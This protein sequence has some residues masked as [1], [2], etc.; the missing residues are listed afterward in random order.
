MASESRR[1][2]R[3]RDKR[4]RERRERERQ[5]HIAQTVAADAK[6]P[7][8]KRAVR[9]VVKYK[10][11]I[12]WITGAIAAVLAIPTVAEKWFHFLPRMEISV[13]IP[14]G[15]HEYDPT[16]TVK[17]V[18][19]LPARDVV[20]TCSVTPLQTGN[21]NPRPGPPTLRQVVTTSR[22]L[23][24]EELVHDGSV[25]SECGVAAVFSAPGET[26]RPDIAVFVYFKKLIF[27]WQAVTCKRVVLTRY[28]GTPTWEEESCTEILRFSN[29]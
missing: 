19:L 18:G 11:R 16:I 5:Q 22:D 1:Q 7:L 10:K 15:W 12:S 20:V 8:W 23:Q 27:F 21:V 29:R 25:N 28:G 3:E 17:N 9:G 24:T 6:P 13:R 4:E 26:R 14:P 2:R